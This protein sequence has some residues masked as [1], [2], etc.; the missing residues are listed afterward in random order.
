MAHPNAQEG[1]FRLQ[2][3]TSGPGTV[4]ESGESPLGS[5]ELELVPVSTQS[6]WVPGWD[7]KPRS[8]AEVGGGVGGISTP[9]ACP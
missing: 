7:L 4:L 2:P 8:G 9:K 6:T 5:A 1:G 3:T